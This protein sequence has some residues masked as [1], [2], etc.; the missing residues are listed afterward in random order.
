MLE[1]A[2]AS[3]AR[4]QGMARGDAA[5]VRVDELKKTSEL[6]SKILPI[7]RLPDPTNTVLQ[8]VQLSIRLCSTGSD[9]S[10][11]RA[12]SLGLEN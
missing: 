6:I 1:S 4:V 7:V 9:L 10:R 8:L 11:D 12:N 2:L 5:A 3:Q